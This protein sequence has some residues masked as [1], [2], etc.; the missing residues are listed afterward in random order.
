MLITSPRLSKKDCAL[1]KRYVAEFTPELGA[2]EL[3]I[4]DVMRKCHLPEPIVPQNLIANF[5]RDLQTCDR[6]DT[7]S[8]SE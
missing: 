8:G 7:I 5:R 2:L 3:E 6:V 4:E 1:T